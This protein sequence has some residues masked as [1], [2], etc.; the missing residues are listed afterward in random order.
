M[1]C[2]RTV[3][4]LKSN[5][6]SSNTLNIQVSLS[7]GSEKL[8]QLI[9]II[10]SSKSIVP[11]KDVL[12]VSIYLYFSQ[13]GQSKVYSFN[14]VLQQK[15]LSQSIKDSKMYLPS[16]SKTLKRPSPITPA[17]PPNTSWLFSM[18]CSLVIDP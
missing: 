12:V 2:T 15:P 9:A 1:K 3:C 13:S 16:S 10:Y 5:F 14:P 17:W 8:V 6:T 18:N 11:L 4:N 7:L